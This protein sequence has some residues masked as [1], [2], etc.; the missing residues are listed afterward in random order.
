MK[1]AGKDIDK[2]LEATR[3]EKFPPVRIRL[4]A[5]LLLS[6]IPAFLQLVRN[7][8]YLKKVAG[9]FKPVCVNAVSAASLSGYADTDYFVYSF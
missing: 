5:E 8:G 9:P 3:F 6:I 1:R 7:R 2:Q 4:G